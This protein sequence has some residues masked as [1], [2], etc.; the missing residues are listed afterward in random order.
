[1]RSDIDLSEPREPVYEE[2]EGAPGP[3]PQ[4]GCR[5]LQARQTY[6]VATLR[7]RNVRGSFRMGSNFGWFCV[8]CPVVVIN[9]QQVSELLSHAM[10]HWDVGNEFYVEGIVDLD[11][12]SVDKRHLLLSDEC[13]PLPLI[14]FK[15]P[16]APPRPNKR[17]RQK[18]RKLIARK[19][20]QRRQQGNQTILD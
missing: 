18:K 12:I 4:C 13:N 11:A 17:E 16:V 3:C 19:L 2:F 1:M 14:E 7:G 5:L 8:R 10:P 6:S 20:K 15:G 9:S